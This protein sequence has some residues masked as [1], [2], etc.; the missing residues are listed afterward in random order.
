[1]LQKGFSLN[2]PAAG[3]WTVTVTGTSVPAAGQPY[4]VA[5][6]PTSQVGLALDTSAELLAPGQTETITAQLVDGAAAVA[7]TSISGSVL[8]LDGSAQPITF[9]DDGTGG[10]VTAGDKIY[11]ATFG[12]VSGCGTYRITARAT[13]NTSEGIVTRD[14][15]SWFDA[16]MAGDTV[17]DPCNPDDDGDYC[18]DAKEEGTDRRLGG[19][20]D[21]LSPWDFF[22]VPTPALS[23][24]S[25]NSPRNRAVN[26][27]DVLA[28]VSY[29]G[30]GENFP[31]NSAGF[32]YNTDFNANGIKDGREYDRTPSTD[33]SQ[34][35]RSGP[36]NG[37]VSIQDALVQ[38]NQVGADCR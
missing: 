30:T 12:P 8:V 22:D 2:A 14:Q 17:R 24:A 5:L 29:A 9:R 36:P 19:Q 38:L 34:P 21:P 18:N 26:T 15:I 37:V 13:G 32:G 10:D 25:P 35:W 31:P 20:R 23:A 33:A 4:I 6:Q 7:P 11:S 16:Q 28:T 27:G 1:M 3:N